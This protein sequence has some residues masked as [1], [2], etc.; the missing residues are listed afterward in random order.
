MQ[1]CF[2]VEPRLGFLRREDAT[3][4]VHID[5]GENSEWW[6]RTTAASAVLH[7]LALPKV[8]WLVFAS[9]KLMAIC[10]SNSHVAENKW[11]APRIRLPLAAQKFPYRRG[12]SP[13]AIN[14]PT[15]DYPAQWVVRL[16]RQ[17]EC[18]FYLH[19]DT[20][21]PNRKSHN[22]RPPQ[23]CFA[24]TETLSALQILLR[25]EMLLSGLLLFT[26]RDKSLNIHC[27]FGAFTS[28][29]STIRGEVQS[30][31]ATRLASAGQ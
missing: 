13:L 22:A 7:K 8:A 6:L 16:W 3:P 5:P 1:L 4:A 27:T 29:I 28:P 18:V 10:S 19:S 25:A 23:I 12:Y 24:Q 9:C 21:V 14:I 30:D 15:R 17:T 11:S 31:L 2:W 26:V 20:P